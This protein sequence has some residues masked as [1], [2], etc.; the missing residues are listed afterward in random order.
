M[1]KVVYETVEERDIEVEKQESLGK[2]LFAEMNLID[3]NFLI[4]G[5]EEEV[6]FEVEGKEIILVENETGQWAYIYKDISLTEVE[7]LQKELAEQ[8]ALIN[9]M[10]GVT[11]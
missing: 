11:E 3:E 10:L 2:I 9:A 5:T 8:K 4:F 1:I 6:P 7:I